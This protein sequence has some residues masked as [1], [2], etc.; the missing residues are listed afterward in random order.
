MFRGV[1]SKVVWVGRTASM[2]FGLALVLALVLGI[3][4][5]ALAA[6]PGDP[7]KLG[8]VNRINALTTLVGSSSGAMLAVDNDSTA[9]GARALDLRVEDDNAP[10]RVNATAG[11]ATN[12][13]ADL[14][15]G[16]E[17][18]ALAEPRGYAHVRITG[19]IDTDYPSKGVNGVVVPTDDPTASLYC[20]DLTF[21]PKVAV[22]APHINNSGVVATATPSA[23]PF[24][25]PIPGRC[26][27][28][29]RDAAARTYGSDT[30]SGAAINFQ[31]VFE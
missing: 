11:K 29:H 1:V 25:N 24:N 18:A 7:F 27:T 8:Q 22:G 14:L 9:T 12:L 23:D 6:V 20:F 4:T 26:P 19:G 15:D 13:N 16:Q 30:G 31:I 21:T 10:M 5:M 17:A 28:T 3:A 2:V